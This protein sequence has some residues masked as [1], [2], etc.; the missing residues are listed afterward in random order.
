[1]FKIKQL[2]EDFFVREISSIRMGNKGRY[3][4]FLLRK[5]NLTTEEA[6]RR[7]SGRFRI[8]RNRFGYAGNKDK[9]AVTE[10]VC[11]VSGRVRE[12]QYPGL[13]IKILGYGGK[14]VS[15]G[16][17]NENEF[18]IV[19]RNL[20]K[21]EKPKKL[22]RI[23]NYFDSQRF[24][25]NNPQIG[26][27]IIKGNFREAALLIVESRGR[28]ELNVA[29][30]LKMSNNDYVGAIR[31]LPK[32]TLLLYIHSCQSK[33]WNETAAHFEKSRKNIKLPIVGFGTEI[34][35][36]KAREIVEKILEREHLSPRDFLIRQMPELSSEGTE[37]D[38]FAE[39]KSLKIGNLEEDELNE[40][41]KK[42][43]LSFRLQKG[44]YATLVASALFS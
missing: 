2:P 11:S 30:H 3:A 29:E 36:K 7:I 20:E 19:A 23:V 38:L 39:I 41:K 35:N 22:S 32:K 21:N 16:D 24:S 5:K 12:A 17:L 40:G 42:C 44:S 25:T 28:G 27:A 33:I 31:E 9:N 1:M 14:P 15:L 37:R 34:K 13:E 8:P 18:V 43:T 26:K 4:Y 10:Q 6:L